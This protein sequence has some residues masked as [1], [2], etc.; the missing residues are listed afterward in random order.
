V[1]TYDV[2]SPSHAAYPEHLRGLLGGRTLFTFGSLE[3]MSRPAI[4]ICGSRDASASALEWAHQFVGREAARHGIVV[5]SG[6]ARGVDRQAHRGVLEAGGATIAV[7]AEGINYFRPTG[8]LRSL[9]DPEKNFL[10]I[11]MFEPQAC[12]TAWRA[13]E[14]NKLIVGLSAGLFVIEARERGGTIHAAYEAVRQNK[15][16]W[17]VAYSEQLPGREGNR[18]LLATSAIPLRHVGDLKHALEQAMSRPPAEVKQ[19]VM[20]LVGPGN[21]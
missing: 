5:V 19:L 2:V 4:G 6:Y 3:L 9:I 7:L 20:T 13:M 10:A 8:E 17:A 15:R 14:R 16:L 12:W 1:I 21:Q 11:S 18:R